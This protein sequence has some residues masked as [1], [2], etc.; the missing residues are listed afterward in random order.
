MVQNFTRDRDKTESLVYFS[1][2]TE[3][4]PRLSPISDVETDYIVRL[5]L[6]TFRNEKSWD[7][8]GK[9]PMLLYCDPEWKLI[10]II[11]LTSPLKQISKILISRR[12]ILKRC[13]VMR[14]SNI[15]EPRKV[16]LRFINFG[17]TW[18]YFGQNLEQEIKSLIN[19]ITNK[20]H[21]TKSIKCLKVIWTTDWK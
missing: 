15:N 9:P 7:S 6:L 14:M 18:I 3:T 19:T 5:F 16:L 10:H 2:E 12:V 17:F 4:R 20:I 13:S 8:A 21:I 1:L 11:L